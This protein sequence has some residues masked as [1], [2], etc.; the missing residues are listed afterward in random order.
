MYCV[1]KN[2]GRSSW[3]LEKVILI[4]SGETISREFEI[5]LTFVLLLEEDL[6][7]KTER[8][9]KLNEVHRFVF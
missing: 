2:D 5:I 3:I 8:R 6:W 7:S 1:K 9:Y 4:T